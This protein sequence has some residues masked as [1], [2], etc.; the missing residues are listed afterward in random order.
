MN[1]KLAMTCVAVIGV[2]MILPRAWYRIPFAIGGS[3][4]VYYVAK[5][6]GR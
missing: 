2:S 5:R 3:C 1:W 6:T 4:L